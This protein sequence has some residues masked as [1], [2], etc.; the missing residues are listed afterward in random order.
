MKKLVMLVED[1][2]SVRESMAQV[3]ELGDYGVITAEDGLDAM[4]K[5]KACK[6][7]LIILD[8]MMPGM[9]GETFV[10]EAHQRPDLKKIPILII[11][12]SDDLAGV[13]K[14]INVDG[15]INKPIDID[16]FLETVAR[17]LFS[18]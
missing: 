11:S 8:L 12:A 17:K 9:D 5:L 14:R 13:A 18:A 6:P 3:I 4:E 10:R 16:D 15:F 7:D 1:D 2:P